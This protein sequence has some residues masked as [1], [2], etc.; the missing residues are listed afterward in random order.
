[1]SSIQI[2]SGSGQWFKETSYYRSEIKKIK[3]ETK[4]HF[5]ARIKAERVILYKVFLRIQWSYTVFKR[6]LDFLPR[7]ILW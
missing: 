7:Q 3:S 2:A 4:M 5:K 6:I 1:M